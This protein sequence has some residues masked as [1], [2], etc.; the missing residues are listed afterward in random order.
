MTPIPLSL[1]SSAERCLGHGAASPTG[2]WTIVVMM[3]LWQGCAGGPPYQRRLR[4]IRRPPQLEAA[5]RTN[6]NEKNAHQ[7]DPAG[8]TAGRHS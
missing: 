5:L 8:R 7:C 2:W 4:P 1:A 3:A 6:S